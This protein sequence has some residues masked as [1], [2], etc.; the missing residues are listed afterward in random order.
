VVVKV[1][2]PGVEEGR[3]KNLLLGEGKGASEVAR[4]LAGLKADA[5]S[6]RRAELVIGAD[7]TLECGGVLFGKAE[8]KEE[9]RSQLV[10]LRGRSHQLHSAVALA[11]SGEV[12][13][14][15]LATSRLV[16]RSFS[17]GFLEAYLAGEGEAIVGALGGYRLEGAGA[18]LF[19][20]IDGDYF[21]ILGLPLLPLLG[22]LRAHGAL[23]A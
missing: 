22:A 11:L 9:A 15:T 1:I 7:Q 20:E 19:D 4:C 6:S 18:Q 13:W 16:M 14:E 5:V 21:S 12:L 10:Q 8:S 3:V 17:D 23:V 2:P